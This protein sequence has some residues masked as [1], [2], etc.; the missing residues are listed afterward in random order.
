MRS[1]KRQCLLCD[2][3][4]ALSSATASRSLPAGAWNRLRANPQNS[5]A[6]LS[7]RRARCRAW[8]R[9]L[10]TAC[11]GRASPQDR[12]RWAQ[13]RV[14]DHCRGRWVQPAPRQASAVVRLT[15][16]RTRR[17]GFTGGIDGSVKTAGDAADQHPED[18]VQQDDE[19]GDEA[20]RVERYA[21]DEPLIEERG[22]RRG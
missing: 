11:S 12:C 22:D 20:A 10:S 1:T 15:A 18:E 8:T 5:H 4:L 13:P 7:I 6:A 14:D 19:Y 2:I 3:D 17:S 21:G 16:V 9:P